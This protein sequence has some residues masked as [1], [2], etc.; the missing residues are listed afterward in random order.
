MVKFT[1]FHLLKNKIS[2]NKII[3]FTQNNLIMVPDSPKQ[4]RAKMYK[5][6]KTSQ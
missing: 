6:S 1:N 3:M 5:E 4:C 2:Y